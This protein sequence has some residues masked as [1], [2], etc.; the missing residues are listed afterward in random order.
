MRIW[1]WVQSPL[2]R[3]RCQSLPEATQ[4]HHHISSVSGHVVIVCCSSVAE[5]HPDVIFQQDG[6]PPHWDL[7]DDGSVM[8]AQ[9]FVL[10]APV[11]LA[12]LWTEIEYML[13][14]A[15]ALPEMNMPSKNLKKYHTGNVEEPKNVQ[16]PAKST[17]E[18]PIEDENCLY[19]VVRQGKVSLQ[20][21][22]DDWIESYKVNREEAC[23]SLMQFIID[24]SGCKGKITPSMHSSMELTAILRKMTEEF[25][26][27]IQLSPWEATACSPDIEPGLLCPEDVCYMPLPVTPNRHINHAPLPSHSNEAG[28]PL[29]K[30]QIPPA[31]TELLGFQP[32]PRE[33]SKG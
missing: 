9:Q 33:R 22:V 29:S 31:I 18:K 16:R 4:G 19:F 10:H 21:I 6:A 5:Y 30:T 23:L 1:G 13:A 24:S 20:L 7:K 26:E 17:S 11:M 25:H 27:V 28:L 12:Y 14:Q 8:V 32:S 3:C 2:V 15:K